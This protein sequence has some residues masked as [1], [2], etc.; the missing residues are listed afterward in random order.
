[1]EFARSFKLPKLVQQDK[2]VA[3]Y[4]NGVLDIVIPKADK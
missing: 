2:I 3:N 4:V 1:M